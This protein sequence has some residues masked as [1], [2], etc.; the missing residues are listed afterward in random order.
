VGAPPTPLREALTLRPGGAAVDRAD[1]RG[2]GTGDHADRVALHPRAERRSTAVAQAAFGERGLHGA[3]RGLPRDADD[4]GA[5]AERLGAQQG[6]VQDEVRRP[7]DQHGVLAAGRL[8]LA[9][10]DHD[11]RPHS[12][13]DRRLGDRAQFFV[14][15]ETGSATP[16]EVDAFGELGELFAAQRVERPV[17]LQMHRQVE[18]LHKVEARRELGKTDHAD[19]GDVGQCLVHLKPPE[20]VFHGSPEP[21]AP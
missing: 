21:G 15:G 18:S 10:V 6:A 13:P 9:A 7:V 12:A 20:G 19:L 14:E 11:D 1:Q 4:E 5:R 8:V 16:L 2:G 3:L 17:H